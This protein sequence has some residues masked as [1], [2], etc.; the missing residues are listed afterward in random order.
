MWDIPPNELHRLIWQPTLKGSDME[1][2]RLKFPDF[3]PDQ[4]VK[5]LVMWVLGKSD[6]TMDAKCASQCAWT[7][8]GYGLSY[9]PSMHG[10]MS[11]EKIPETKE[12]LANAIEA[13]MFMQGTT[14]TELSGWWALVAP[15]AIKLAKKILEEFLK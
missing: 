12:G 13:K 9:I 2:C 15:L 5:N 8:A 11:A 7:V 3:I 6:P 14:A 1:F 4:E 10:D